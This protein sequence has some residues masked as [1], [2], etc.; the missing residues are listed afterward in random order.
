MK[1]GKNKQAFT[2]V[3]LLV[4]IVVIGILAAITIVSY[5]GIS[6]KAI[7]AGLQSDL[8]SNAKL[9]KMY[10]VEHGYYPSS[11]DSTSYCPSSPDV[12]NRYC[13]KA[14]S[15]SLLTY[16]GGGQSFK[17]VDKHINSGLTYQITENGSIS[18]VLNE[19][20]SPKYVSAGFFYTCSIASDGNA[21][22]WGL[23]DNGQLGNASKTN[24]LIPVAVNKSGVLNGLTL[25][26]I[27]SGNYHN[28]SIASDNMV[29][30]WGN[31]EYGQLGD[32]TT[33]SHSSPVLFKM[34][35]VLSGLTVKL[36]E[37]GYFQ[38]CAIASDD[39]AYCLGDNEYGQLGN[40]ST[41]NSLV[42]VAVDKTGVLSGLSIKSLSVG[43]QHHACV[44]ASDNNAYCWGLGASGQLGNGSTTSSSTPVAVDK[45]GVLSGLTIKSIYTGNNSTCVIASDN[46]AYCWGDNSSGRLGNNSTTSSS[47]PVAVYKSGVLN[48][49]TL[50]S[51]A[52]GYRHVCVIASDNNSYCWGWYAYGQLGNGATSSSYVPSI[53]DRSGV[54]NGLT[55][56]SIEADNYFTCAVASNG[57]MYCWGANDYGQLGNNSTATATIPVAVDFNGM[58]NGLTIRYD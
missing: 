20:I 4:V 41:S 57:R 38:T 10:N 35:G 50:K 43:R 52:I 25:K 21:Y 45:T 23:N 22:C 16:S 39:N 17:L 44:I 58:L 40:N 15:G 27:T 47:V 5:S 18:Q 26:S 54:L 7:M 34:T 56:K 1:V 51:M 32:G 24:S 36:I 33:T 46:N 11:I 53:V 49:L 6:N 19:L 13:L 42:P 37:G 9:L 12:D 3:E 48:G 2:I 55:I 30:C 14:M 31:N 8:S 29:Y 28:C